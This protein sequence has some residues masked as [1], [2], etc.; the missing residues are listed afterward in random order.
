MLAVRCLLVV[1]RVSVLLPPLRV[2]SLGLRDG[3]WLVV[4][5]LV[6]VV[7]AVHGALQVQPVVITLLRRMLTV[8][9]WLALQLHSS[10]LVLTV[11]LPL[12][13]MHPQDDVVRAMQ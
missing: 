12:L 4:R 5:L 13:L 8:L 11:R 7:S 1:R 3:R 6:W 9:A 2:H 10:I